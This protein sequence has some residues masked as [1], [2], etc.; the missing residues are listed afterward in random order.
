MLF[1]FRIIEFTSICVTLPTYERLKFYKVKQSMNMENVVQ[2]LHD[3]L[4]G[5]VVNDF[6]LNKIIFTKQKLRA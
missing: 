4:G 3:F 6:G 1:D 5:D 2:Y